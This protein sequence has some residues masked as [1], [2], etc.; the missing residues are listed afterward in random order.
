M[1]FV[2]LIIIVSVIRHNAPHAH[3][4]MHDNASLN[5]LMQPHS[6]DFNLGSINQLVFVGHFPRSHLALIWYNLHKK[7]EAGSGSAWGGKENSEMRVISLFHIQ[8][9][10]HVP[11]KQEVVGS[12]P[13]SAAPVRC[14]AGKSARGFPQSC[15]LPPSDRAPLRWR[16]PP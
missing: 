15:L 5:V 6:I 14:A 8:A 9:F 10:K 3:R 12:A 13:A 16:Y 7:V 4:D 2:L 1:L 11:F